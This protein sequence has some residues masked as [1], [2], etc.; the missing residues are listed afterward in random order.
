VTSTALALAVSGALND[1]G[2]IAY[3]HGAGGAA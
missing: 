1:V 3:E 2:A